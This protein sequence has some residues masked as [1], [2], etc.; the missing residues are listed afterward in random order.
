MTSHDHYLD[1]LAWLQCR[2]N[3]DDE[4]SVRILTTTNIEGFTL[5][6]TDVAL[7]SGSSATGTPGD[8]TRFL[9]LLRA[10]IETMPKEQPDDE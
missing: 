9:A 6:L 3:H 1:V 8:P 10:Q 5:A 2:A 7:S 4:G